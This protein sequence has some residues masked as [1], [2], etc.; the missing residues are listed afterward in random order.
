MDIRTTDVIAQSS[1]PAIRSGN[2]K[3]RHKAA[4]QTRQRK[5]KYPSNN[6]A[7]AK[8]ITANI[9]SFD[10]TIAMGN[11]AKQKETTSSTLFLLGG[12]LFQHRHRH[13]HRDRHS[14]TPKLTPSVSTST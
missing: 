10:V 14:V 13:R 12:L 5:R 6:N 2:A 8:V 4:T 3:W 1:I 9:Y 11:K 7:D